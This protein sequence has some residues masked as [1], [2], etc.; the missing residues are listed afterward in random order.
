ML[1]SEK[2]LGELE[3]AL[4]ELRRRQEALPKKATAGRMRLAVLISAFERR[5]DL[6][7]AVNE[8]ENAF[9]LDQDSGARAGTG[10]SDCRRDARL[11]GG[12]QIGGSPRGCQQSGTRNS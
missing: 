7:R 4:V 1:S 5:R 6:T 12:G 2:R 8:K 3:A 11:S 10:A 9:D